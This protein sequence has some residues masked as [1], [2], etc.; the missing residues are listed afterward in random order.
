MVAWE[1]EDRAPAK[2]SAPAWSQRM[3]SPGWGFH[4]GGEHLL[5]CGVPSGGGMALEAA[6]M[7]GC[8][9]SAARSSEVV[10]AFA[11][12]VLSSK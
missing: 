5:A 9:G 11:E 12:Q 6:W 2:M 10:I 3:A 1:M 7:L 4:F 8:V